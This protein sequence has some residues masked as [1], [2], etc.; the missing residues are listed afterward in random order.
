MKKM[1]I[2][3][4]ALTL[5]LVICSSL[6]IIAS[7]AENDIDLSCPV[8]PENATAT[9]DPDVLKEHLISAEEASALLAN[10]TERFTPG[11]LN[12]DGRINSSDARM[13][14]RYSAKLESASYQVNQAG[15]V[16]E[17][18]R[19]TSAD[20]RKILRIAA[21]L[22]SIVLERESHTGEEIWINSLSNYTSGSW[23]IVEAPKNLT[24][25]EAD[26][27]ESAYG[28][29]EPKSDR[30]AFAFKTSTEGLYKIILELSGTEN[31]ADPIQITYLYTVV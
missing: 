18:G 30:Q 17:D 7:S 21:K 13:A 12:N 10:Q 11:D 23:R 29:K 25:Y 9:I 4:T 22:D 19:L 26:V 5:V 28:S 20:A 6:W 8:Y 31:S 16:N 24:I 3:L 15:D 1:F 2:K 27:K 14:L